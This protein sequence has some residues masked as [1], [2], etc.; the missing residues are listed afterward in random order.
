MSKFLKLT[1]LISFLFLNY[2]FYFH[3]LGYENINED[4]FR[5][6]KRTTNFYEAISQ[7]NYEKTYQQYHPGI[8]L[9]YFLSLGFNSFTFFSGTDFQ[10]F[11]DIAPS[12]FPNFNFHTK[13]YLVIFSL[14]TMG[15][16]T[17]LIKEILGKFVALFFIILLSF[18]TYFIGIT[19]NLH[20][21]SILSLVIMVSISSF[22]LY[23]KTK[24]VKYLVISGIYSGIGLL[25]KSVAIIG[26][27]INF[28][29]AF[30]YYYQNK[31][32][33]AY[34]YKFLYLTAISVLV[35]VSLFPS[36]WVA[37]IETL[38]KIYLKGALSTGL[39]GEDTFMHYVQGYE[40]PDPGYKF[41]F[42]VLLFRL[43]PALIIISVSL[44]SFYIYEFLRYKKIRLRLNP[45][46]VFT[47]IF[48]TLYFIVITYSMK[49]T[50]RY[51]SVFLPPF[52]IFISYFLQDF[53][54]KINSI[55]PK[56]IVTL[57]V[58]ATIFI[59][60]TTHPFYFAFYSPLFGGINEAQ[61]RIY[62]NQGGIGYL[63]LIQVLNNYPDTKIAAINY[64]EL[65]P[66]SELKIERLDPINARSKKYLKI[67]S[68]QQAD[69]L[70]KNSVLK[71][72]V[73]INN[74]PFWRIFR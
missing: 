51:I 23:L 63:Q 30:Y 66:A 37:P 24:Q 68:L 14:F 11:Q 36:M 13:L 28:L 46:I 39:G 71:E 31:S 56:I 64:Q 17:Y 16:L 5:W 40:L 69:N 9:I 61:K 41:Y 49:K 38:S 65:Q 33:L 10:N 43:S 50:D 18:D 52:V 47:F 58:L 25:T 7:G 53:W 74:Q 1:F 15:I 26:F 57:L 42:F 22:Y 12:L 21:D 20:L 8:S 2:Y 73:Y 45:F 32:N 6:Y 35:F 29:M 60:V 34:F 62:I 59:N 70:I 48:M 27:F 54:I 55:F 3:N 72:Y 19:R 44:I 4:Q 67:T